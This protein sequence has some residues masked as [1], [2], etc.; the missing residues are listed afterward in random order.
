M[1]KFA[2]LG[3]LLSKRYHDEY[4]KQI[5]K[6]PL[7]PWLTS[8]AL[9]V[10]G[11]IKE[12]LGRCLNKGCIEPVEEGSKRCKAH[13]LLGDIV[14]SHGYIGGLSKATYPMMKVPTKK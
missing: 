2:T 5:N 11:E 4:I 8:Q 10:G 14:E 3:E 13:V 12:S 6:G 9:D 1:E 7:Y